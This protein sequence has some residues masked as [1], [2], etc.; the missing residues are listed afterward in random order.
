MTYLGSFVAHPAEVESQSLRQNDE[1][2]LSRHNHEMTKVQGEDAP[3]VSLGAGNN[4]CIGEIQ[5]QV[6]VPA[7]QRTNARQVLIAALQRICPT[8]KISQESIEDMWM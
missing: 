1:L 6:G 4:G 2:A 7:R 5:R 3:A 8:F